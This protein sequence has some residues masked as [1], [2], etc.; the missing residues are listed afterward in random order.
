MAF[1]RRMFSALVSLVVVAI[2]N[3]SWASIQLPQA[4]K[5]SV[6]ETLQVDRVTTQSHGNGSSST[7]V[8]ET[9]EA[10]EEQHP[11][12]F[13][14]P[15]LS[16]L[17]STGSMAGV[18][19]FSI[20]GGHGDLVFASATVFSVDDA[21]LS[22]LTQTRWLNVPMPPGISLLRPPQFHMI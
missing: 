22:W 8:A 5:L 18:S 2:A 14:H 7:A 6:G 11:G 4:L 19:L 15:G 17:S 20:G 1:D 16:G 12:R 3:V 9:N 13:A 21:L 10:S